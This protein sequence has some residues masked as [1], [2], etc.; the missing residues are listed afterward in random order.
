MSMSIVYFLL[1][2]LKFV[3]CYSDKPICDATFVMINE[4]C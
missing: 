4:F 3:V 1:M 2:I